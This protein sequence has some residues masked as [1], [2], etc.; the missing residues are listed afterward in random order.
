MTSQVGCPT[1]GCT[2]HTPARVWE[3]RC[4]FCEELR[5]P[6][7]AH[8]PEKGWIC[9]RCSS[10]S[11]RTRETRREASIRGTRTMNA[12]LGRANKQ[13]DNVGGRDD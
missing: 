6:Y 1:C 3:V 9:L 4:S 8:E 12:R 5:W 10:L 13:D 11:P 2:I 7:R